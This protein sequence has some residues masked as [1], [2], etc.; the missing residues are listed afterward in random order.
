[1]RLGERTPEFFGRKSEF[2]FDD[3]GAYLASL[4]VH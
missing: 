3:D 1:M 2:P 4:L